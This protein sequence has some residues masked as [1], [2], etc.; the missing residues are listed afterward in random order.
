MLGM[1]TIIDN[2]I[3]EHKAFSPIDHISWYEVL[4]NMNI[5]SSSFSISLLMIAHAW[6]ICCN[7]RQFQ[8]LKLLTGIFYCRN[9]ESVAD[10]LEGRFMQIE[11]NSKTHSWTFLI[12]A[13][14]YLCLISKSQNT[15]PQ[16]LALFRSLFSCCFTWI[17][18]KKKSDVLLCSTAIDAFR[19]Q[20]TT[21]G[22]NYE[23]LSHLRQAF[24]LPVIAGKW[25]DPSLW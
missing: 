8:M 17:L 11:S 5:C 24:Q 7:V 16:E 19:S 15:E 20:S 12:N 3:P 14:V 25:Q 18:L 6:L 21:A 22:V 4:W 1:W 2:K 23:I 9:N 13:E 10:T